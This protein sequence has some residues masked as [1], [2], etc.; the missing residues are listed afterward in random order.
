M[1]CSI[2]L[3]EIIVIASMVCFIRG[4]VCLSNVFY[5]MILDVITIFLYRIAGP[6]VKETK[7]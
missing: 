3:I 7:D 1:I 4:F 2:N 5:N 6:V